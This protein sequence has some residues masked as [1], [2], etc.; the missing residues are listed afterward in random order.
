M[1]Q[2]ENKLTNKCASGFKTA[3]DLD[4]LSRGQVMLCQRFNAH[5]FDWNDEIASKNRI[6]LP[7]QR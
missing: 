5:I 2:L 3:F 6:F 4:L 1:S 7:E